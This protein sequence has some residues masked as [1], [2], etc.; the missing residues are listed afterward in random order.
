MPLYVEIGERA[1]DFEPRPALRQ[2]AI[3]NMEKAEN[4]FDNQKGMFD[5]RPD[6]GFRPVF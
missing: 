3:S 5:P 6:F 4:P 1:Y 2:P